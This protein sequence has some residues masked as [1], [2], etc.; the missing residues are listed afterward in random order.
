MTFIT[1]TLEQF[2]TEELNML[3]TAPPTEES[4]MLATRVGQIM[5][6]Y[7]YPGDLVLQSVGYEAGKLGWPGEVAAIIGNLAF[8]GMQ[9]G[10]DQLPFEDL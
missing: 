2:T 5:G 1:R 8:K 3:K 7:A 9:H 4:L 10:S 6:A